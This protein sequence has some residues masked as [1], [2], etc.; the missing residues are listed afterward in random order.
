MTARE[1]PYILLVMGLAVLAFLTTAALA[2]AADK[3]VPALLTAQQKAEFDAMIG[4]LRDAELQQQRA[5]I[6][7]LEAQ[8]AALERLV[9]EQPAKAVQEATKRL[10]E[11]QNRL[12]GDSGC[13]LTAAGEW[14]TPPA[15]TRP[16]GPCGAGVQ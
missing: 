14:I 13:V 15:E 5:K 6:V 7:I 9:T 8:L 4:S 11:W 3:T 16:A 12:A 1:M 2:G 10:V